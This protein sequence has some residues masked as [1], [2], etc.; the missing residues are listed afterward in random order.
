VKSLTTICLVL[1]F[2]FMSAVAIGAEEYVPLNM[3]GAA[4][5][6]PRD[7]EGDYVA[8]FYNTSASFPYD[9][10]FLFDMGLSTWTALDKPGAIDTRLGGVSGG[11]MVGA[12]Q[13]STGKTHGVIY[14]IVAQTWTTLDKPG[15]MFTALYGIDGDNIVGVY[16]SNTPFVYNTTD[17]LN[18]TW[19]T[20]SMANTS[21]INP[22]GISG[23]IVV[24]DYRTAGGYP[25]QHSFIYD[26]ASPSTWQTVDIAGATLGST[27]MWGVSDGK[28]VGDYSDADGSHGF[29]YDT[30]VP[31]DDPGRLT[32]IDFPGSRDTIAYGISGNTIVGTHADPE[33]FVYTMPV[34]EPTTWALIACGMLTLAGFRLFRQNRKQPQECSVP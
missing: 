11:K 31:A 16:G 34:P 14:D 19:T 27:D 15:Q 29:L 17:P 7:V 1:V 4:N 22:R 12:Y 23:N 18:P 24:G 26:L 21:R 2:L 13:D 32:I 10:A 25:V 6:Y 3:P 30:T 20:L 8:G 28:I 9:R 5:T 33:G